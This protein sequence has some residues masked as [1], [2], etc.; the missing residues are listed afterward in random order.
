MRVSPLLSLA[1]LATLGFNSGPA[2]HATSVTAGGTTTVASGGVAPG[3]ASN[4]DFSD[5]GGSGPTK[6]TNFTL[7]TN[8]TGQFSGNGGYSVVTAPDGS[9]AFSSGTTGTAYYVDN[10]THLMA[11]FS[12]TFSGDFNVWLLTGNTDLGFVT[13]VSIGLGFNNG[14]AVTVAVD[15]D[16]LTTNNFTEFHVTGA[17]AGETFQVYATGSNGTHGFNFSETNMGGIT[18]DNV[19]PVPEPSSLLLIGT[20][21]FGGI[22]ALRRKVKA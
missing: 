17:T 11:T 21:L 10:A 12:P 18:F 3:S 19:T 9:T 6:L 22:S 4:Y 20:G 2:A 14:T 15:S 5:F 1:A 16:A 8:G 7:N 13:D